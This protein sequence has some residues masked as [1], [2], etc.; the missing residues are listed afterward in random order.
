MQVID[1]DGHIRESAEEISSYMPHG[2][3]S[4]QVFPALDHLHR[5]VLRQGGGFQ[6]T[7]D[8]EEWVE[9]LDEAGIDWTVV[10]PT[11]GLAVG[12]ISSDDAAV[13]VCRA[14]NDWLSERFARMSP[15]IK[16]VA[17]LPLQDPEAA[18]EELHRAVTELHFAAG[19]LPSNGEGLKAHLGAKMF[20]PLYEEAE[21]LGCALAV[22]G[23]CHHHL[24]MDTFSTFYGVHALG[25]PLGIMIQAM[26]MLSHG[27]FERFPK[28]RVGYLEGGA[29]WVPFMMDRL[30]RSY[31]THIQLDREGTQIV[32]PEPGEKAS[33]YFRR[34]VRDGRI[35]VGFDCDDETLGYACPAPDRSP[36]C[37]PAT[38]PTRA[39]MPPRAATRWRSYSTA[40]TSRR[41]TS[42][43]C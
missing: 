29:A 10:Y 37:S 19:M 38:S 42:R 43:R 30:D 21:K 20:W 34:H 24:G 32:G 31:H 40:T 35:F 14:Y 9:F 27:I 7:P 2:Q 13:V 1:A 11:D 4:S 22:H 26:A 39:S 23:G 16:G 41:P 5:S 17:L 6:K 33:A 28:L 8:A 18:A 25:H 36:S 12:R 15:R 3:R